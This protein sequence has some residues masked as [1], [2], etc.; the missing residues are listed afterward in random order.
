MLLGPEWRASKMIVTM[1]IYQ[2]RCYR[3]DGF[4]RSWTMHA[5]ELHPYWVKLVDAYAEAMTADAR[6]VVSDQCDNCSAVHDCEAAISSAYMGAETA[7][8]AIPLR[9][10]PEAKGAALR[11]LQRASKRLNAVLVGLEAD[12]VASIGKRGERVPGFVLDAGAGSTAWRDDTARDEA[13]TLAAMLDVDISKSGALTA[14]QAMAALKRAKVPPEVLDAYV[15][16]RPGSAK[17]IETTQ[18]AAY[19]AFTKGS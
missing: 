10:S 19:K 2:P 6:C 7:Y 5:Y 3:R 16:Y 14:L 17:L 13:V 15:E 18:S 4:W 11:T 1:T 9:L 12:V 8:R